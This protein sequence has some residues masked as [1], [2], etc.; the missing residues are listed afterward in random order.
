MVNWNYLREK[1]MRTN[2]REAKRYIG[3][4]ITMALMLVVCGGTVPTDLSYVNA[5][6]EGEPSVTAFA[7]K[8]E[9][10]TVFDLDGDND[11]VGKIVFGKNEDEEAQEWYIAGKDINGSVDNI[12][13]FTTTALMKEEKFNLSQDSQSYSPEWGCIYASEPSS[14]YPNHYGASSLRATMC[15]MLSGEGCFSVGEKNIMKDTTVLINDKMAGVE[16]SVTDVLYLPAGE[17]SGTKIYVGS[18]SDLE[19]SNQYWDDENFWLCSPGPYGNFAALRS[20]G[21][22]IQASYIDAEGINVKMAVQIDLSNVL[23]ASSAKAATVGNEQGVIADGTAMTLRLDGSNKNIGTLKYHVDT[24]KI[25]MSEG[26]AGNVSFVMQGKDATKGDWYYSKTL[27]GT[28]EIYA[29]SIKSALGLSEDINLAE[30]EMWLETTEDALS[31]AVRGVEEIKVNSVE[32]TGITVPLGGQSFDLTATTT[33]TGVDT[34]VVTWKK[35]TVLTT[36]TI[37]YNTTYT[38]NVRLDTAEG[39][40]FDDVVTA[41]MDGENLEAGDIIYN[42]DGTITLVKNYTSP[43]AK[44]ISISAPSPVTGVANGTEKTAQTLGLP[45]TV[46]IQTED[47]NV[48][49]ANVAWDLNT[50]A[51]GNYDP[52]VLEEQSFVVN[53]T[54]TL[55]TEINANGVGLNTT[56]SVTVDEADTVEAPT[57]NVTPGTYDENQTVELSTGTTGATIYY[58]T[59]GSQPSAINGNVYNGAINISGVVGSSIQKTITAIAVKLGMFDSSIA[60]FTYTIN[61]PKYTLTVTNGSGSGDYAKGVNVTLT[62]NTAPSGKQFKNWSGLAGLTLISGNANSQSVTFVMPAQAVNVTANYENKPVETTPVPPQT[63]PATPEPQETPQETP[64]QIA[65]TPD[66]EIRKEEQPQE[67]NEADV[68]ETPA[69]DTTDEDVTTDADD[70]STSDKESVEKEKYNVIND[71]QEQE[72]YIPKEDAVYKLQSDGDFTEFVSVEV[73]GVVLGQDCYTINESDNT[74]EFTAEY[75]RQLSKGEHT[76]ILNFK[77]G[78]AKTEIKVLDKTISDEN[79]AVED[80][81]PQKKSADKNDFKWIFI[82]CVTGIILAGGFWIFGILRN[83]KNK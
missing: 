40:G 39:Y 2:G 65:E 26:S 6:G 20:S 76:V 8:S 74:I 11:T 72:G 24:G 83:K 64:P 77:D 4:L 63:P 59:D 79:V 10:M 34:P 48:T 19:I 9:L 80:D 50:L 58:T 30:C 17:N 68:E 21:N 53:G 82:M 69:E 52:A 56:I 22:S 46:V 7:E 18:E 35:G 45:T 78:S 28:E 42:N 23:F 33:T 55:P 54:V 32:V 3:L 13:L 29:S 31:Y 62:A 70:A 49:T 66:E 5:A 1:Q 16:Y 12:V 57:V 71:E 81:A 44:L 73:D 51:S 14:V 75:M 43:K 36:G 27:D 47:A 37:E 15:G 41:T 67:D 25:M 61:I 38:V 60:T